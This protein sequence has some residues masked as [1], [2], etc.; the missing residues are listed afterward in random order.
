LTKVPKMRKNNI[1]LAIAFALVATMLVAISGCT[2]SQDSPKQ[3]SSLVA[4]Q[5]GASLSP[6]YEVV[7]AASQ[8]GTQAQYSAAQANYEKVS[9]QAAKVREIVA[10]GQALDI[11]SVDDFKSSVFNK[12]S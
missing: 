5:M 1:A 8:A 3:V 6:Q 2:G 4:N 10:V 9:A 11:V 7:D 12:N